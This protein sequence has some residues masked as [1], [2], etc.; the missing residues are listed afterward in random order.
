VADRAAVCV[1]GNGGWGTALALIA[2]KNGHDVRLWGIDADYVAETARTRTNPRY[3]P[4]VAL[5]AH[6]VLTSDAAVAAR[7]AHLLVSAVPTQYLRATMT[8]IASRLP[9]GV[10]VVSVTKGVENT[11]LR[12]PTEVLAETLGARP[13][14]VLSGPSHAEEVARGGPTSV[15]VASADAA[16]CAT[17]QRVF[18]T[19]R[20]RIYATDDVV[21]VEYAAALKNVIAIAAGACDGLGLGDN[22]KAALITRGNAEITRLGRVLGARP[23][24]FAGLAGIGDLIT[25]CTSRHGRNR[26]V[27]ERLGRG[28]TIAQILAS[29]VQVAE[30]VRTAESIVQLARSK[31]VEMPICE[32]VQRIVAGSQ[33]PEVAM[34]E[35]MTRAPRPERDA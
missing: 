16:L 28:E 4:G 17:V 35:L 29:M 32:Q 5:P 1:L 2:L 34:Q 6:L 13:I 19:D 21:G 26:A 12:R 10:P 11:T 22:A 9:A 8:A 18:G 3:L 31:G 30:G 7:G 27:G 25:T 33:R 15:V 14:A 24:T 23:E 20:M